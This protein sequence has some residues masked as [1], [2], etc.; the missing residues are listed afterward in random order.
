MT[1]DYFDGSFTPSNPYFPIFQ[2]IDTV[3]MAICEIPDT[4]IQLNTPF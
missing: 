4:L 2:S 3:G 1:I